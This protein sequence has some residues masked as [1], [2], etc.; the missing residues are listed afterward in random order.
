MRAILLH[1]TDGSN[2]SN[3]IPW[4]K[5]QLVKRGFEVLHLYP[6]QHYQMAKNGVNMLSKTRHSS[7]I[8]ILSSSGTLP[9]RLLFQCYCKN[10]HQEQELK[11]RFL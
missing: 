10:Y 9:V 4:L 3:W 11:R 6:M 1:G 2:E 5:Q 8:I 7:L